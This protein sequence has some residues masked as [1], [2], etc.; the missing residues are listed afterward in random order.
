MKRLPWNDTCDLV[1]CQNTGCSHYGQ[2]IPTV[3]EQD[4]ILTRFPTLYRDCGYP[5]AGIKEEAQDA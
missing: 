3:K 4:V 5:I 2:G 1:V